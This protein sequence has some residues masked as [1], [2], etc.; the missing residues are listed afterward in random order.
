M[1]FHAHS[2]PHLYPQSAQPRLNSIARLGDALIA[3]TCTDA[4]VA[5]ITRDRDFRDFAQAAS[6][7]LTP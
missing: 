1:N 6:L 2:L 7:L 5:L 4:K 3:Q